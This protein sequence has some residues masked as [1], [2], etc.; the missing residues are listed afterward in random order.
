MAHIVHT[1]S[2]NKH[3]STSSRHSSTK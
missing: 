1:K 3:P 2:T